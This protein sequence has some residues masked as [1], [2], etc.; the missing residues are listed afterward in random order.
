M[1]MGCLRVAMDV[2]GKFLGR[3]RDDDTPLFCIQWEIVC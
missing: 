3:L 2:D 1:G